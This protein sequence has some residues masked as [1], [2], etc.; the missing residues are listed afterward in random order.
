MKIPWL[1]HPTIALLS[2]ILVDVW[3]WTPFIMLIM[4]A[5]LESIPIEIY[6]AGAIDGAEGL[7]K[8][9]RLT[10]PLLYPLISIAVFLRAIDAYKMFDIAYITTSGGPGTATENAS[11]FAY[12]QGF[13][14]FHIGYASACAIIMLILVILVDLARN[15]LSQKF[16]K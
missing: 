16:I 6:E 1:V 15:K 3:E 10:L 2:L 8:F 7:T 5:G 4:Y 12:R 13:S 9:F 11:L 14:F